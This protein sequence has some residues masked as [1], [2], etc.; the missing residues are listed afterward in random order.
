MVTNGTNDMS[1]MTDAD[2]N[3]GAGS[4][5]VPIGEEFSVKDL[6]TGAS[7]PLRAALL[8][9]RTP[10]LRTRVLLMSLAAFVCLVVLAAGLVSAARARA[11]RA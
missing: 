2:R 9:L 4:A 5:A 1:D 3:P 11:P 8:V 10:S 6:V 7:F